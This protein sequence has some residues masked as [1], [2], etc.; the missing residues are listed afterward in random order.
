VSGAPTRIEVEVVRAERDGQD[1]IALVLDADATVGDALLAASVALGIDDV[2]VLS[3]DVGIFGHRCGLDRKLDDG[4]RIELYRPLVM[5]AKSARRLRA[6]R[7][8]G[9]RR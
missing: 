1:T 2:N 5:D 3:D 4:D 7:G 6:R 9:S 8:P